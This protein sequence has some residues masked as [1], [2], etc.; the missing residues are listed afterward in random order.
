MPG[1]GREGA[2]CA[3]GSGRATGRESVWAAFIGESRGKERMKSAARKTRRVPSTLPH[4]SQAGARLF[5]RRACGEGAEPRVRKLYIVRK[6]Y[7]TGG[8]VMPPRH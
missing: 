8:T 2:G 7:E 1:A 4:G 5:A 6:S 3:A